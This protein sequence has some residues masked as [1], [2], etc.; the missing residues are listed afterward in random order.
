MPWIAEDDTA[1]NW[2][3]A[4]HAAISGAPDSQEPWISLAEPAKLL[5][6]PE[7]GRAEVAVSLDCATLE[8]EIYHHP[9]ESE[10]TRWK[11][12]RGPHCVVGTADWWGHMP[13]GT[14][15]IGDLKTGRARPDPWSV[16]NLFYLLA[17][18]LLEGSHGGWSSIIWYPRWANSYPSQHWADVPP[19]T[20]GDL[21]EAIMVA[22]ERAVGLDAYTDGVQPNPGEHCKYC[23]SALIC[24]AQRP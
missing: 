13:D 23:P 1:A 2:G 3:T 21:Y 20:L 15:W 18:N 17:M 4:M 8:V 10:R 22:H 11:M 7:L 6:P 5:W 16:Q 9:S 12:S 24:P 14:P 19:E